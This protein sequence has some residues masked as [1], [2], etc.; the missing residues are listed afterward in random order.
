VG[1]GVLGG[2]SAGGT[3]GGLGNGD[4]DGRAGG[5]G[6]EGGGGGDGPSLHTSISRK[7]SELAFAPVCRRVTYCPTAPSQPMTYGPSPDGTL[8]AA[9]PQRCAAGEVV[10]AHEVP[11]QISYGE[12]AALASGR[13]G[14]HSPQ[15]KHAAKLVH[16]NDQ[17][18]VLSAHQLSH[19]TVASKFHIDTNPIPMGRSSCTDSHGAT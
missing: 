3:G 1:G 15:S 6:K 18:C 16:L 8:I 13:V 17:G 11:T 2:G 7:V 10:S 12:S 14:A 4:G 19:C 9:P 5:G